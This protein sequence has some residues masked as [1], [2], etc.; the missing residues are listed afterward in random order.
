MSTE[1]KNIRLTQKIH[2]FL[3]GELN[4]EEQDLF[5]EEMLV[6]PEIY[7]KVKFEASLRK[8]IRE[9]HGTSDYYELNDSAAKSPSVFK[10]QSYQHWVLAVAAV[11]V[12]VIGINL[13]R[14]SSPTD[15]ATR[16]AVLNDLNLIHQ[17][18]VFDLQN[19]SATRSIED[20]P[21][22]FT[23]LFDKSLLSIFTEET[24]EALALYQE[25]IREFPDDPRISKAHFNVGVIYYN[26]NLFEDAAGAFIKAAELTNDD[27]LL[28]KS[29]WFKANAELLDED[30]EMARYSM[31]VVYGMNGVFKQEAFRQLRILDAYLGLTSF[32]DIAPEEINP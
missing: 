9:K 5:W 27:S 29:W 24:D 28:E 19:I 17:I 20:E 3:D 14:I 12:L 18:D 32:E 2:T 6:N 11:L 8:V 26:E 10:L 30:Y 25:L 16:V 31:F 4:P 7:E 1:E 23:D 22:P 13:L 21:D 15:P